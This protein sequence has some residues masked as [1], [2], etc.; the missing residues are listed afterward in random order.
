[1]CRTDAGAARTQM[2]GVIVACQKQGQFGSSVP[3]QRRV[4]GLHLSSDDQ[5]KRRGLETP[6]LL[7]ETEVYRGL[8]RQHGALASLHPGGFKA[9]HEL[10][11]KAADFRHLVPVPIEHVFRG[12]EH[13]C[14]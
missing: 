1:M 6:P 13:E 14:D 12:R 7:P 3:I 5:P 11:E 9:F 2:V 8:A 10:G 4:D